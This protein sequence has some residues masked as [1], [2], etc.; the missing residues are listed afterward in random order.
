MKKIMK[1]IPL[2]G[3][4]SIE[5]MPGHNGFRKVL[6]KSKKFTIT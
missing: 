5:K 3:F 2:S 1:K 6:P 4:E